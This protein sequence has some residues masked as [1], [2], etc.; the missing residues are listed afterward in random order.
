MAQT[1][2]SALSE[3]MVRGPFAIPDDWRSSSRKS[4]RESN[5]ISW[6]RMSDQYLSN[7]ISV[8]NLASTLMHGLTGVCTGL[9]LC[10][11]LDPAQGNLG[12]AATAC[13]TK[14]PSI[15]ASVHRYQLTRKYLTILT[16]CTVA[17]IAPCIT[18]SFM[19]SHVQST[20]TRPRKPSL[21]R[22]LRMT[23]I[24]KCAPS[25]L[26]KCTTPAALEFRVHTH[27]NF[28][29]RCPEPEQRDA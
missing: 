5:V 25:S 20:Q 13:S 7:F 10:T 1:E 18:M 17:T 23:R 2:S 6:R 26:L 24:T 29:L 19:L 15:V 12:K 4:S 14:V 9:F 27:T 3:R 8:R 21:S 22:T 16:G 11:P 28:C